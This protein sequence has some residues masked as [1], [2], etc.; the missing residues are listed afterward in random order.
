MERLNCHILHHESNDY[1]VLS[2]ISL[3]SSILV[4]LLA[5]SL[6]KNL[7][8]ITNIWLFKISLAFLIFVIPLSL[9][10]FLRSFKYEEEDMLMK[11]ERI[12]TA[13]VDNN[14]RSSGLM[15]RVTLFSP[16]LI[17]ILLS[18]GIIGIVLSFFISC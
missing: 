12:A 1:D 18:L 2:P 16:W 14:E 13:P 8:I 3:I 11:F 17:T 7:H 15:K 6:S 4:G 5:L 9:F 10:F